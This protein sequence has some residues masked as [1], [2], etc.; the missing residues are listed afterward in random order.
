M[1]LGATLVIALAGCGRVGFQHLGNVDVDGGNLQKLTDGPGSFVQP[2]W[3]RDGKHIYAFQH[4]ETEE[5]GNLA[6]FEV[7]NP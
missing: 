3:S 7:R 1:R 4:W 6:V 2:S 5:F